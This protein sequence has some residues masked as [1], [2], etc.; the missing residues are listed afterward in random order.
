MNWKK[1]TRRAFLGAALAGPG[2]ALFS[3]RAKDAQVV[4]VY[5]AASLTNALNDLGA[6]Y[7]PARL[8]FS[9]ASSATLAKQ[10]EQGAPADIFAS[11]D[12]EWMDYLDKKG[13]LKPGSRRDV[14]KG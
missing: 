1:N 2:V 6:T 5:A 12:T 4:T 11:A 9:F 10:I 13:L 8:K 14:L 3:P 7:Q